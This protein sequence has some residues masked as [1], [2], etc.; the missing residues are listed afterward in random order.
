MTSTTEA[1]GRA[2][3]RERGL[4]VALA[5]SLTLNIF[6]AGGLTWSMMRPPPPR[7]LPPAERLVGAARALDLTPDQR[8]ALHTFGTSARGLA[9]DLRE[10]NAPL[11]REMW[12]QM[13][14]P[15]PD[16]AAIQALSDKVLDNR[17]TYQRGMAANLLTFLAT[18]SPDQ[19]KSFTDNAMPRAGPARPGP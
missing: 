2:V 11:M 1:S 6:V 5:L 9:R 3:W 17:R 18:L 14:L 10:A 15:Q 12:T 4:W 19:R 8:T 7:P 16:P 13:A